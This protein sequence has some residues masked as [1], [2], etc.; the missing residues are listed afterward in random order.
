LDIY[1]LINLEVLDCSDNNIRI[2]NLCELKNLKYLNFYGRKD[3]NNETL[4][5]LTSMNEN[6]LKFLKTFIIPE[7]LLQIEGLEKKYPIINNS[8]YKYLRNNNNTNINCYNLNK[9]LFD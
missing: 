6:K 5:L 1:G 7:M 2:L 3:L 9:P 8:N 4:L